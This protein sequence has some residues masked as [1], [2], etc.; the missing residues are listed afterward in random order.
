[1]ILTDYYKFDKFVSDKDRMDCT[2]ST[3]NYNEFEATRNK[4]GQLFI[5]FCNI[6]SGFSTDAKR[7]TDKILTSSKGKNI[8]SVFTPDVTLPFAYGDV[9]NTT[10][11]ILII[12]NKDYSTLE[13]FIARGQK[14]NRINLWQ[15]LSSEDLEDEILTLRATAVTESVTSKNK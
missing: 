3:Q 5:Y 11:A 9:K 7:K 12:R 1:M 15:M 8:S 13:I 14:N 10:D 2:A 6:P 4:K